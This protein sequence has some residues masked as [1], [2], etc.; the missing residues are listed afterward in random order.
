M[1][2]QIQSEH[3]TKALYEL[4]DETNDCPHRLSSGGNSAGLVYHQM[5]EK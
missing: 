2:T 1:S 3:F 5:K 4:L